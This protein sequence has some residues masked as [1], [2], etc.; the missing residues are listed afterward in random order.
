M[1]NFDK[2]CPDSEYL[3]ELLALVLQNGGLVGEQAGLVHPHLHVSQLV[4]N[5]LHLH[6]RGAE[7]F[8]L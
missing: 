8:P 1:T 7:R 3:C 5:R 6:D 4:L 2:D